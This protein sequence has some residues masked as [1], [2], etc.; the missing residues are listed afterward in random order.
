M[1]LDKIDKRVNDPDKVYDGWKVF[2][3]R[4]DD[5]LVPVIISTNKS[6]SENEWNIDD[7]TETLT[8]DDYVEEYKTGFH[9]FA[10]R[11]DAISWREGTEVVRKVKVRNV[12]TIGKQLI[13]NSTSEKK[14]YVQVYVGRE[15]FIYSVD[16]PLTE[17]GEN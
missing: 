8:T 3:V 6:F 1:C 12:Q 16:E 2:S 7:C 11:D 10:E 5:K 9:V 15:L 17:K 4:D 14:Q 13:H